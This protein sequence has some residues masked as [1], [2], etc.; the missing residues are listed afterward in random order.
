MSIR[1][2]IKNRTDSINRTLQRRMLFWSIGFFI[3]AIAALSV[4]IFQ[5]G[6]TEMVNQTRQ[7]NVQLASVISRDIN[8]QISNIYTD[9][10]TFSRL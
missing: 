8:S 4:A 2:F 6:Q 7:R 9:T 5:L 3:M 1:T 10:R